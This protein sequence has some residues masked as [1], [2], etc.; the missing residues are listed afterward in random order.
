VSG[1]HIASSIEDR[2]AK[3]RRQEIDH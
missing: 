3:R 2:T 1:L